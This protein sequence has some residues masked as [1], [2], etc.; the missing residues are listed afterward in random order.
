[1][2][3]LVRMK[4]IYLSFFVFFILM[5]TIFCGVSR[6]NISFHLALSLFLLTLIFSSSA[7][8]QFFQDK[9]YLYALISVAVFAVY[10]SLSN[11]WSTPSHLSSSLTHSFYLLILMALYR[12]AELAGYKKY[13]ITAAWLGT[14]I[15]AVLTLALVDKSHIFHSRLR[16]GF[17]WS[18]DNV[19][20]LGGYMALGI[21]FSVLLM[22]EFRSLWFLAPI[23][24][25]LLCLILTQSRGPLMALIVASAVTAL[26]RPKWNVKSLAAIS[27]L[28]IAAAGL[29][30]ASGFLDTFISRIDSSYQQSFVRFG[31]WQH[32]WDVAMQKP[33]FGWGFEKELK[34]VNS[35]GQHITTTHSL[36]FAA[37]LKGGAVGF[38][39]F[40][41]V[42]GLALWRCKQHFALN[43]KAEVAIWL[44]A[45]VF[46]TTQG[47][48]IISNPR[49]YWV[50]FWLP[51]IIVMSTPVSKV[52]K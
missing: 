10:Y 47:M 8:R 6:V 19:I 28:I 13:V 42:I 5:S 52:T 3:S 37:L 33:I 43:Q 35:I 39:L 25:L 2:M 4:N 11:L 40:V 51:L 20:D 1:M 41:F 16:D 24:L 36:Y 44:F 21:L 32:A 45:L 12:Q 15:L 30:Y 29:L 31:I 49:E 17:P 27:L 50:L 26:L 9:S 48:F 46:Y 34:F 14:I 23:P 38:I 22:R 18:P 7:R